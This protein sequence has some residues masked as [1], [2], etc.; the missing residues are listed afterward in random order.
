MGHTGDEQQRQR[1]PR[2]AILDLRVRRPVGWLSTKGLYL[3]SRFSH[4]EEFRSWGELWEIMEELQHP[5]PDEESEATVI[6]AKGVHQEP[7]Q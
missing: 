1:E 2:I 3:W 7:E 5:S 4:R 6:C